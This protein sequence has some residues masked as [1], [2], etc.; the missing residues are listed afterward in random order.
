MAHKGEMWAE[1]PG[2]DKGTTFWVRIP[3]VH[4]ADEDAGMAMQKD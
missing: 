3:V 4:P 2:I 1:S